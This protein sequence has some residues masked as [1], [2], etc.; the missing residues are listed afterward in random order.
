MFYL[1][2]IAH[3]VIPSICGAV[4]GMCLCYKLHHC[5]DIGKT[6]ADFQSSR[7]KRRMLQESVS[8]AMGGAFRMKSYTR[9]T[10]YS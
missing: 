6:N 8:D 2:V 9:D 3:R 1:G 4:Y 7:V 5:F 10:K